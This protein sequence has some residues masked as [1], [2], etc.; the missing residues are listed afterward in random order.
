MYLTNYF[1]KQNLLK[2]K[3]IEIL[4]NLFMFMMT[5]C[6]NKQICEN[7]VMI[8]RDNIFKYC[9]AKAKQI[10]YTSQYI[11]QQIISNLIVI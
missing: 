4:N 8:I 2:L 10:N 9:S 6:G 7:F 1:F 3:K 5:I 11:F